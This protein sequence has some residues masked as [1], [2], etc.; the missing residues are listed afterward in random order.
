M[1]E[2][3]RERL[4]YK[5]KALAGELSPEQARQELDRLESKYKDDAFPPAEFIPTPPPWTRAYLESLKGRAIACRDYM[6]HLAEVG[7]FVRRREKRKR[8]IIAGASIVSAIVI[9]LVI[10][11]A[12]KR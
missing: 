11:S 7:Y 1:E 10:I 6:Q 12:A 3:T 4:D 9:L 2:I 5:K 8:I